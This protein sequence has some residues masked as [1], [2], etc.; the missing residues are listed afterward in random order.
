M[1]DEIDATVQLECLRIDTQPWVT[2][3]PRSDEV[4]TSCG[5]CLGWFAEVHIDP[6]MPAGYTVTE[7]HDPGCWVWTINEEE[8][9]G[10]A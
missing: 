5:D 3:P 2:Y 4:I 6:E 9:P 7:W 1:P 8:A 10:G